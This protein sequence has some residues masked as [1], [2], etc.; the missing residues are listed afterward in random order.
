M[1]FDQMKT[2]TFR[3]KDLIA[4]IIIVVLLSLAMGL[5][6]F[7]I[8][9]PFLMSVFNK[10]PDLILN[11]VSILIFISFA[12]DIGISTNVIFQLK[13]VSK[14]LRKDSTEEIS[15]KVRKIIRSK[16]VLQR[17]LLKAFPNI[18]NTINLD[19]LIERAKSKIEH[20]KK[21]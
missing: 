11:I 19:E 16:L 21:W 17:R 6:V 20:I 5:I 7:Y 4:P 9:N 13:G 10:I 8:S 2:S 12:I 15:K 18:K 1:K 3:K 14:N